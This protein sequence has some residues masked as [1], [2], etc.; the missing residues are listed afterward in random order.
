[1]NDEYYEYEPNIGIKPTHI[2]K[3]R[4]PPFVR[5]FGYYSPKLLNKE[6]VP[7][8]RE[9]YY[10]YY[11]MESYLTWRTE[12]RGDKSVRIYTRHTSKKSAEVTLT[13]WNALHEKDREDYT[14]NRREEE[15]IEYDPYVNGKKIS[16]LDA[17]LQSWDKF[18]HE[19]FWI[20]ALDLERVLNGFSD[21]DLDIYI[22]A[23]ERHLKQK[24]IATLIGKSEA[25][26]SQRMRFIEDSIEWNMIDDGSLSPHE[27][28]AELEYRKYIR[29]GKSE[30]FIDV[31]V[32]DFMLQ[33]PQEILLRYLFIFRGQ[34]YF[35]RFCFRWLCLYA[36]D[37]KRLKVKGRDVL[38][39]YSFQLYK[40]Y[41]INL[42][43]RAQ[44]L[45]IALELESD[46]L[47]KQYGL[48]DSRPNEKFIKE[49]EKAANQ[50]GMTVAEYRDKVL[51]PD[52]KE[53][54]HARF[55]RFVKLHPE[56]EGK[57]KPPLKNNQS[58]ADMR[59]F[60][61]RKRRL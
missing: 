2:R 12:R 51:F 31:L 37:K 9:G 61:N 50:E 10:L 15:K 58:A 59:N 29:T 1:M 47:V 43:T 22:Y 34:K 21:I 30:S 35:I 52:G 33:M 26:V 17:L 44:Q 11:Y 36:M 19:S 16:T 7:S 54:I 4:K 24:Q 27:I 23:K 13:Q 5:E 48:R 60:V 40:K 46:R 28:R 39:K 42:N 3:Q 55:E 14:V 41:A 20:N 6:P 45:F 8:G 57:G 32:Y 56:W 38:N 53:R 25:Y 18:D 49:I